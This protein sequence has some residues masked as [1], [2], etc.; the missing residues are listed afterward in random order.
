MDAPDLTDLFEDLQSTIGYRFQQAELLQAAL[1]HSSVAP[2]RQL[3][4]ERLEFLGDSALGLVVCLEIYK[5]YPD[6][7]EGELTKIKSAVVSRKTCA[8]IGKRMGLERFLLLGKGVRGRENLPASMHA[9]GFEAI[10]GAILLDAGFEQ[11]QLFILPQIIP[12]I[13]AAVASKHQLNYKSQLQHIV[14]KALSTSPT[15]EVVEEQGPDHCKCFE[16]RVN[17]NGTAYRSAWGRSK[18]EAEQLAA[19][20]ALVA[21][22][23]LDPKNEGQHQAYAG[24]P[25]LALE[26]SEWAAANALNPPNPLPTN[27]TDTPALPAHQ[28][29]N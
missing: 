8:M 28:W 1:T 29:A 18:K 26:A 22:G 27:H 14:Q 11:A 20:H 23:E 12:F 13:E 21:L 4:N 3:S 19:Y 17:V 24:D 7:C 2:S 15:Y 5:R 6:F 9:A 10:I 16:I 25:F